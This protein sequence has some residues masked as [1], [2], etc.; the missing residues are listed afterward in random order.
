MTNADT[1]TPTPMLNKELLKEVMDKINSIPSLHDLYDRFDPSGNSWTERILNLA[2]IAGIHEVW[3]QGEWFRT[4][5]DPDTCGTAGCFAGWTAL[6]SGARPFN[7]MFV[8]LPNVPGQDELPTEKIALYA[9][10]ILGLTWREA[11][12]LFAAFNTREDLNRYVRNL[13]NDRPI[14][15][16]KGAS[17]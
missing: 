3:H 5:S 4:S 2:A 8:E 14:T 7:H 16:M 11:E 1:T 6:L 13:L 17:E 9:Q 10:R 12:I 15:S